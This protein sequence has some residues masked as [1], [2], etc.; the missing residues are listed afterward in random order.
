MTDDARSVAPRRRAHRPILV[1]ANPGPDSDSD[2][3]NEPSTQRSYYH[4]YSHNAPPSPT[5]PSPSI[6]KP[7]PA[8]T[9]SSREPGPL[10][11]TNLPSHSR[12]HPASQ[13]NPALSSPSGTSSPPPST[14][15]QSLPPTDF[16]PDPTSRLEFSPCPSNSSD[17]LVQQQHTPLHTGSASHLLGKIKA[18][19]PRIHPERHLSGSSRPT[20]V[21]SFICIRSGVHAYESFQSP[22]TTTPSEPDSNRTVNDGRSPPVDKA[23]TRIM[24]TGDSEQY[25][26]V[27]ISGFR[28]TAFI[29]ELIF[30]KV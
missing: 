29:K 20:S 15:G 12:H 28:N 30:S 9:V 6:D 7:F 23:M 17:A 10:T 24:V 1:V 2:S 26:T 5:L 4:P 8:Q 14:P 21:M 22:T 25:Y 27:D 3:N 13:S 16:I 11:T 19:I 18:H